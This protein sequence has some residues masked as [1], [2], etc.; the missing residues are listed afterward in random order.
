MDKRE[1]ADRILDEIAALRSPRPMMLEFDG[2]QPA[3]EQA[4][5]SDDRVLEETIVAAASRRQLVVE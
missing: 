4:L 3:D 1:L 5:L 2:E